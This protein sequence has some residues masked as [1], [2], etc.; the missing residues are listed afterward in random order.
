MKQK[1]ILLI[2]SLLILLLAGC[3]PCKDARVNTRTQNYFIRYNS[4]QF[5]RMQYRN[6]LNDGLGKEQACEQVFED[7]GERLKQASIRGIYKAEDNGWM[8]VFYKVD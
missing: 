8:K 4:R 7:L 1:L 3:C 2:I 5:T 6:Y